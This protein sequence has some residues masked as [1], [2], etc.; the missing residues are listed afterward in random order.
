[1][2]NTILSKFNVN[3]ILVVSCMFLKHYVDSNH[4][5]L[6]ILW[7]CFSLLCLFGKT[8]IRNVRNRAALIILMRIK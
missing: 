5:M 8:I 4:Y 7:I 6:F 3:R 1:M 2:V